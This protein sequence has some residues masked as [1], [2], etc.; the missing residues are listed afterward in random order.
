ML[1][2][3]RTV[4]MKK[5]LLLVCFFIMA[6]TG[7]AQA[8]TIEWVCQAGADTWDAGW[9]N[10]LESQGYTVNCQPAVY[11]SLDATEIATLNSR[12]L[13]VVSRTLRAARYD[14]G[15]EPIDWSNL[16]AP[17]L[18]MDGTAT[19]TTDWNWF[20]GGSNEYIGKMEV[21]VPSHPYFAGVPLD[22]NNLVDII[23]FGNVDISPATDAGNGDLLATT[24]DGRVWF[25]KWDTGVQYWSG[26]SWQGSDLYTGAPR[27]F[28]GQV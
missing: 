2:E 5:Q 27:V 22:E 25:A 4:V 19:D 8:I 15:T 17:M 11:E 3:E 9:I 21:K 24:E 23:S 20:P 14:D 6:V 28:F 7:L 1:D 26:S 18:C 12:D 13:I 10:L 16:T